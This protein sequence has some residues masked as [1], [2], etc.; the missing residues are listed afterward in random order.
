MSIMV[1]ITR[2]ISIECSTCLGE[3]LSRFLGEA[4][5]AYS[6]IGA[7]PAGSAVN[8]YG[9]NSASGRASVVMGDMGSASFFSIFMK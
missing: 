4:S 1:I 2:L 9:G 5:A 6:N 7:V 3:L 8:S